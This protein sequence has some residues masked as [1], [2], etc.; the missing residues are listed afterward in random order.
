MSHGTIPIWARW[1]L[2]PALQSYPTSWLIWLKIQPNC[3]ATVC[4]VCCNISWLQVHAHWRISIVP[5]TYSPS[6]YPVLPIGGDTFLSNWKFQQA[7][8]WL[9]QGSW[10]C[11]SIHVAFCICHA[12]AMN[13]YTQ[14]NLYILQWIWWK[15]NINPNVPFPTV[16]LL[17]E[18][19]LGNPLESEWVYVNIAICICHAMAISIHSHLYII[20]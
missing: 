1:F 10:P 18:A 20:Q 7:I 17:V 12:V 16:R 4:R 8:S 19:I 2:I 11:S 13:Q 9:L 5:G 14:P 6:C 3:S 15:K